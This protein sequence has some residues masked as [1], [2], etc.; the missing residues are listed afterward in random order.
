ML[1][2]CFFLSQSRK[3]VLNIK[4]LTRNI[5]FFLFLQNYN[6]KFLAFLRLLI[7]FS[8]KT[9]YIKPFAECFPCKTGTLLEGKSLMFNPEDGTTEAL[10]K[11]VDLVDEEVETLHRDVLTVETKMHYKIGQEKGNWYD[12]IDN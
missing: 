9:K 12:A 8:M 5:F 1:I 6:T 11:E 3:K 4:Q 10:A 7:I 2:R